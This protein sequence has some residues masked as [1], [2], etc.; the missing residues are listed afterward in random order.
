MSS[1]EKAAWI[2][3]ITAIGSYSVYVGIVLS[4]RQSTPLV[5]VAYAPVLL[6]MIVVSVAATIVLTIFTSLAAPREAGKKDRRDREIYRFGEYAGRWF[7]IAGSLVALGLAMLEVHPFWIANVLYLAFVLSA[8]L[9]SIVKIVSY[10][11]GMPA[12]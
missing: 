10:R 2:G 5:E 4:L 12:W 11:R 6:W 1:E 3:L 7:V 8:I 9:A